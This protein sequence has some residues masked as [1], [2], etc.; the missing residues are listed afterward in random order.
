[1]DISKKMHTRA[2]ERGIDIVDLATCIASATVIT[3]SSYPVAER[4][5]A[6]SWVKKAWRQAETLRKAYHCLANSA[7]DAW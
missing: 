3:A 7:S 1:M 5:T 4:Q 6:F 2:F